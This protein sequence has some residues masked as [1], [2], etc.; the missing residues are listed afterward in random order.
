M[1]DGHRRRR[2]QAAAWSAVLRDCVKHLEASGVVVGVEEIQRE[3]PDPDRLKAY[4]RWL[5]APTRAG[6]HALP[7]RLGGV[8]GRV[9]GPVGQPAGGP[10]A[11]RALSRA[12][13]AQR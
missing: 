9:E 11:A 3:S 1:Q 10:E 13:P 12:D 2:A 6:G 4:H 5:L 7:Q 8:G